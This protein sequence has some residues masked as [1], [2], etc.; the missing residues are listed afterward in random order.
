LRVAETLPQH[1]IQAAE[2]VAGDD[3]AVGRAARF[4]AEFVRPHGLDVPATPIFVDEVERLAALGP[5]VQR[6][7]PQALLPLRP[8]LRPLA[9]RSARY[10]KIGAP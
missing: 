5:A 6:R 2:A 1:V 7:T 4:V 10:A 8:V 9:A 3:D